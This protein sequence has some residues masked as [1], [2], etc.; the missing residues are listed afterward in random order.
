MEQ[1]TKKY[2]I[3]ICIGIIVIIILRFIYLNQNDN[4]E[5]FVIDNNN[6]TDL[7]STKLKSTDALLYGVQ[8]ATNPEHIIHPWSNKMYNM[9][10]TTLQQVKPIA[11]YK[12]NLSINNVQYCKLG[13]MVSQDMNY[14]LPTSNEFTLLIKKMGSD[15][16][17]PVNYSLVVDSGDKKINPLY[18]TYA[19]YFSDLSN[20]NNILPNIEKLFTNLGQLMTIT[21]NNASTIQNA[22]KDLIY[23]TGKLTIVTTNPTGTTK[24]TNIAISQLHTMKTIKDINNMTSI[25]FPAGV[26]ANILNRDDNDRAVN[27]SIPNNI[28]SIKTGLGDIFNSLSSPFD[29]LDSSIV[30]QSSYSVKIFDHIPKKSIVECIYNFCIDIKKFYDN[31]KE[32]CD[33]LKLASDEKTILDIM[34]IIDNILDI[35]N[36]NILTKFIQYINKTTLLGIFFDII[37]NSTLSYNLTY[38]TFSVNQIGINNPSPLNIYNFTNNII[39]NMST[40]ILNLTYSENIDLNTSLQ[41]LFSNIFPNIIKF[42]TFIIDLSKE[43]IIEFPLQIYNPLPPDGYT[44]LGHIF[45]NIPSD[46][47]KIKAAQN[48]ACVPSN[49]VKEI[50]E[51]LASD[52]IFE[53]NKNGVYWALYFNP[54]TGTFIS[55][56]TPQLPKGKV[57]KVVACVTKCTAV[58][59]L[60]KA[61]E[62]ARQ[63]YN[64]NKKAVSST[65]IIPDLV[66]NQEEEFYLSKIKV[67]SDSIAKL[68]QRAQNMQLTI[69]KANI[70]NRE[71]NKNKLQNYV[72][73]QK[74]NIGIIMK[75]LIDDKNKIHT[76]INVKLETVNEIIVMIKESTNIPPE[77]KQL[78]INKIIEVQKQQQ[79]GVM[80][81]DEYQANM[82][83]VL[84]S[85][86]EYDLTGLVKKSTVSD[87]CYGCDSPE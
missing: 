59:D 57:S 30:T 81:S 14:N 48:V 1:S 71:M 70:I 34:E 63:Y 17:P 51:W 43:S 36:M 67:Q 4:V 54:Y 23:R 66:S 41:Y 19:T 75:K 37:I 65:P 76:N 33:Y 69:D 40:R 29:N 42:E 11:L 28:D 53:Y 25:T 83:Q 55:T 44:S 58:D 47:E 87:V 64:I 24:T 20:L 9:Q 12:P 84:S 39:S 73:T 74:V 8:Q 68:G 60:K 27:I 45:C 35:E 3:Y 46:L 80:T 5:T 26:N 15:I 86:P 78:L 22:L 6:A 82:N 77:Q 21:Q 7:L 62:C 16:K 32:L 61:D 18:Y 13:D 72:D 10:S 85:C 79:T 50:R 56:N 49:C 52:K 38:V 2:L 31:S